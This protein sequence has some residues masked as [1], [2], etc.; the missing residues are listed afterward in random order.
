MLD[1][2][3]LLYSGAKHEGTEFL[4]AHSCVYASLV[5]S[6]FTYFKLKI[7]SS[8]IEATVGGLLLKSM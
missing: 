1:S 4:L 3:S 6:P 7:I 8:A 2:I 5:P